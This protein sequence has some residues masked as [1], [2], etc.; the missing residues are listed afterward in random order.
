MRLGGQLCN[1]CLGLICERM[2]PTVAC[3][4]CGFV[5]GAVTEEGRGEKRER[6]KRKDAAAA[7]YQKTGQLNAHCI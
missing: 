3:M 5:P 7:A 1:L 6:K 4:D 2:L